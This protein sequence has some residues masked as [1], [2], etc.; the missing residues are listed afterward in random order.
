MALADLAKATSIQQSPRLRAPGIQDGPAIHALVRAC[1]PLDLNSLY[2]YLLLCLHHS[3]TCVV[4]ES[5]QGIVGFVSAY[6]PPGKPDTLFVWQ[7]AVARHCRGQGLGRRMLQ[8]LLQRPAVRS[9]R[10]IETTVGP[11]NAASRAMFAGWARS[12]GVALSSTPLFEASLFGDGHEAEDLL[13]L[14]PL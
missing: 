5:A 2:G 10:F 3:G 13:R 4:A 11:G 14:G 6:L 9:V 8:H 12:L 7:V 1:P